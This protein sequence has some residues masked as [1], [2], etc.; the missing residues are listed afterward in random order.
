MLPEQ[1]LD[2]LLARLERR[3]PAPVLGVCMALVLFSVLVLLPRERA[4]F[5]YFQF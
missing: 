1:K 3:V 2:A 5:I 4:A